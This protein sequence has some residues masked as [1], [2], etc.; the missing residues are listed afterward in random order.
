MC[1]CCSLW[2]GAVK[3]VSFVPF[4]WDC[5]VMALRYKKL[6]AEVWRIKTPFD[7]GSNSKGSEPFSRLFKWRRI[8]IPLP[9]TLPHSKPLPITKQNIFFHYAMRT[10]TLTGISARNGINKRTEKCTHLF[11]SPSPSQA[12][13]THASTRPH[14][15]PLVWSTN[16]YSSPPEGV[17]AAKVLHDPLLMCGK[18]SFNKEKLFSLW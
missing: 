16:D 18:Y 9:L 5:I 10:V 1:V 6:A 14:A 12:R 3:K 4:P 8:H 17:R 15:E 2:L 7:L 13:H 11:F